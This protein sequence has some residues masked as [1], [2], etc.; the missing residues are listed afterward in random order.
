VTRKN[1]PVLLTSGRQT[2]TA[3]L[4]VE[5]AQQ[6]GRQVEVLT[7]S[8]VAERLAGC[9]VSWCGGSNAADR[10]P[11]TART[12]NYG[13]GSATATKPLDRPSVQAQAAQVSPGTRRT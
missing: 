2:S 10:M 6:R 4:L 5:V 13:V 12:S 9:A 11:R 8:E 1:A 3:V 7:R